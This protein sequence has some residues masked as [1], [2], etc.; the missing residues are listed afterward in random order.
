MSS[1]S[2]NHPTSVY[3]PQELKEQLVESAKS[4][5]FEIGRGRRSCLA[6]FVE[7]LLKD[8]KRAPQD[9]SPL[10]SLA[11]ELRTTIAKLSQMGVKRQ[12]RASAVLELL[13][14]DWQERE[15]G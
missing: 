11:P 5:G 15:R 7:V 13:L 12:Q 8:R 6:R 9:L 10:S 14:A 3:L 1:M 2:I 4:E